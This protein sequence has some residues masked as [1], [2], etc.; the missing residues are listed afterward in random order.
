MLFVV[1]HFWARVESQQASSP[2]LGHVQALSWCVC[3]SVVDFYG[4]VIR[5]DFLQALSF[6]MGIQQEILISNIFFHCQLEF[7][8]D[9]V[10]VEHAPQG[11]WKCMIGGLQLLLST[12]NMS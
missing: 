8:D 9:L 3:H 7:L 10:A 5:R 12:L 1:S 11:S 2:Y 4:L 6:Y